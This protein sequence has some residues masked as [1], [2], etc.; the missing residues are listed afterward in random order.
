MTAIAKSLK[1]EDVL[2]INPVET[3][4]VQPTNNPANPEREDIR[5]LFLTL[6]APQ[7][8][9]FFESKWWT[10]KGLQYLVMNRELC[11]K[12][13]NLIGRFHITAAN[14]WKGNQVTQNLEAHIIW[15][16]MALVRQ[17]SAVK[18]EANGSSPDP[19]EDVHEAARKL[20]IFEALLT[21]QPL[22]LPEN[23]PI[24]AVEDANNL[25]DQMRS[26]SV[27]FWKQ[28]GIFLSLSEPEESGASTEE[29]DGCL[30]TIRNLLDSREHRDI[31]YSVAIS[32][33][34]GTRLHKLVEAGKLD[35]KSPINTNDEE[36]PRNKL[37]V[38]REF[39]GR[40][41][42][43]GTNQIVQRICGMAV[44]SWTT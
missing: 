31:L 26:R 8:D 40:E 25:L 35:V 24:K 11:D 28:M 30:M 4:A 39:I 10:T 7:I 9:K 42:M 20:D 13:D 43:R 44:R 32:R 34:L 18:P 22:S 15:E 16:T 27:A 12:Y 38:A 5:Q 6:Y 2:N 14:D 21:N 36:E 23:D 17:A 1:I 41:T 33:H 3:P 37:K 19:Q 29:I